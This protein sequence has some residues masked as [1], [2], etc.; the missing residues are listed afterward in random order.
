MCPNVVQCVHIQD[1]Q[2]TNG[3]PYHDCSVIMVE[4]KLQLW[5][6]KGKRL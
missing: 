4:Y 1:K 6:M 3:Y 2:R 5:L